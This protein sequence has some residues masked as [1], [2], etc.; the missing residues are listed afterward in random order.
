[1]GLT[2]IPLG[3]RRPIARVLR[4]VG[5]ELVGRA[6]ELA[7]PVPGARLV[8]VFTGGL[9]SVPAEAA[10]AAGERAGEAVA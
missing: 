4:R 5:V 1:M 2:S 8:R 10:A 9:W 3:F 6:L 7:P